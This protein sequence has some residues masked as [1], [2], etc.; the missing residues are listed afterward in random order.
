M[1]REKFYERFHSNERVA[2]FSDGVFAIVVTLLVLEL[3]VP[4]IH[5]EYSSRE[6]FHELWQMKHKFMS[7]ALSFLFT[8]NLWFSHN[9]FFKTLARIDNVLLWLNNILLLS[10]CFIP[11]PTS[12]IGDYPHNSA[13][14][15]IFGIN[16]IIVPLL[17]YLMGTRSLK[18]KLISQHVDMKRYL[19]I[20]RM[21]LVF[22]PV[23]FVPLILSFF[24]PEVALVIYIILLFGGI[25]LGDRVKLVETN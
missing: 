13:G 11:Y 14:V 25:I 23:G 24:F 22:I 6:L 21:I 18:A 2:F 3:K 15:I 7:F 8:V 19:E 10:I 16:W 20:R 9:Q 17:F 4:E 5:D 1:E 12:L